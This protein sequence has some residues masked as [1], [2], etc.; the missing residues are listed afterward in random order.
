MHEGMIHQS[1]FLLLLKYTKFFVECWP[2][3][4]DVET[5]D[6]K[7]M[8]VQSFKEGAAYIVHRSED[9]RFSCDICSVANRLSSTWIPCEKQRSC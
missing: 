6:G 4:D 9:A 3:L 1:Q 5:I 7:L 8:S 2:K